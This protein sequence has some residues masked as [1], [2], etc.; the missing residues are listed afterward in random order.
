VGRFFIGLGAFENVE[1]GKAILILGKNQ[2]TDNVFS[3]D[4]ARQMPPGGGVVP[5]FAASD[6]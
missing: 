6:C 5:F 1:L 4:L 2:K 3:R